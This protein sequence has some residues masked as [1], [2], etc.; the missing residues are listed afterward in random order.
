MLRIHTPGLR[1]GEVATG[2]VAP[3]GLRHQVAANAC[4][5]LGFDGPFGARESSSRFPTTLSGRG[6]FWGAVVRPVKAGGEKAG[7]GGRRAP[8]DAMPR[9]KSQA[10]DLRKRGDSIRRNTQN[11]TRDFAREG[12][13]T[14]Q[15]IADDRLA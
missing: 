4:G 14:S 9:V 7:H 15:A 12:E 5:R 11:G 8:S 6:R 10:C 3:A 1:D 13:V 2:Q